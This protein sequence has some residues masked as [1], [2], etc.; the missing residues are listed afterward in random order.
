MRWCDYYK[1]LVL[2]ENEGEEV[3]SFSSFLN[4]MLSGSFLLRP[5]TE[6][7]FSKDP[8][9]HGG[10]FAEDT[11]RVEVTL[12]SIDRMRGGGMRVQ[13]HALNRAPGIKSG[14]YELYFK[15]STDEGDPMCMLNPNDGIFEDEEVGGSYMEGMERFER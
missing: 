10:K 4:Q 14:I 5:L 3:A 8:N 11:V 9:C 2:C 6:A 12:L 13:L 15:F 7:H 1:A